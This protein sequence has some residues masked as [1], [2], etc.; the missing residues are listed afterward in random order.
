MTLVIFAANLSEEHL[1]KALYVCRYLLGSK[2]YVLIYDG[3]SGL[4][5]TACTDADW[6]GDPVKR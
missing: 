2:D 1:D 6:A 3:K 5:L 4:G